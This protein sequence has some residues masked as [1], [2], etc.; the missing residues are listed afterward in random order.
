MK[1]ALFR[2]PT[3]QGYFKLE[4]NKPFCSCC[5]WQELLKESF[6][7]VKLGTTCKTAQL[8]PTSILKLVMWWSDQCHLD[9]FKHSQPSTP[10]LIYC[11]FLETSSWN[12]TSYSLKMEQL[13]SWLHSGHHVGSFSLWWLLQYLQNNSEISLDSVIYVL[14]R[15][16]KDCVTLL[17]QL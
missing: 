5:R 6:K 16:T 17:S 14:Q 9:C 2:K 15:E 3:T 13:M 4:S 10:D 11:H 1:D 12:Y 8:V 7:D